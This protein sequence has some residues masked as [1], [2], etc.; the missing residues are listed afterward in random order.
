MLNVHSEDLAILRVASEG[1][2]TPVG[3][4]EMVHLVAA[5]RLHSIVS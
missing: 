1:L 5:A 3:Q 4:D 2:S